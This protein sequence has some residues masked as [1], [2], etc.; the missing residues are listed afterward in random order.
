M[1]SHALATLLALGPTPAATADAPALA[2]VREVGDAPLPALCAEAPPTP[3]AERV[4]SVTA[5][6][7]QADEKRFVDILQVEGGDFADSYMA[8]V[9]VNRRVG[10]SWG[11]MHWELE[12]STYGHW[13]IEDHFEINAAAVARWVDLP[14][15][16]LLD[17]SV[18]FG[19]GISLAD[20]RPALEGETRRFLHHLLAEIEVK[21]QRASAVSLVFRVH[22]RSGAF[23]L[24]GVKG[25]SNFLT[26]GLRYRF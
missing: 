22:H 23:G 11:H 8:G 2:W 18:A 17:T 25:G 16:S 12:G 20:K 21:P 7:G 26:L 10:T 3:A 5:F 9:A 4:W 6:L 1:H 24:Y 14:W 13:G 19:Q 15:D